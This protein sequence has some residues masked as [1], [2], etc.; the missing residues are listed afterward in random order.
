MARPKKVVIPKMQDLPAPVPAQADEVELSQMQSSDAQVFLTGTRDY[1]RIDMRLSRTSFARVDQ[2]LPFES[3]QF[4]LD[5][6]LLAV[7]I[8][9]GSDGIDNKLK[10]L[11]SVLLSSTQQETD[12]RLLYLKQLE[13]KLREAKDAIPQ[14]PASEHADSSSSQATVE[15]APVAEAELEDQP[16]FWID[17]NNREAVEALERLKALNVHVANEPSKTDPATQ[18]QVTEQQPSGSQEHTPDTAP[19]AVETAAPKDADEQSA[20]DEKERAAKARFNNRVRMN[21]LI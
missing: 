2:L 7:D 17:P 14:N 21:G 11:P 8:Y 1:L 16:R 12:L 4:P 13:E 18:D 15:Q 5:L 10:I 9:L 19:T 3:A 20:L 6:L